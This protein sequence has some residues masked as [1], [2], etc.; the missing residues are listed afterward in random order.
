MADPQLDEI[1]REILSLLQENAR[2]PNAA[3]SDRL[4]VSASTVGKRLKHLEESGVI[5]GYRPLIDY[6]RIGFSLQVLFVCTVGLADRRASVQPLLELP[7]VVCVRELMTG[8]HNLHV[9]VVG[10]DR[11]AIT[12]VAE[13]ITDLGVDIDEETLLRDERFRP[14]N[15]FE[16]D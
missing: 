1:D 13:R 14:S 15:V 2:Y 5:R 16:R 6:E 12:A 8:Q 3:I 10:R 11:A 7:G 9:T 4:S